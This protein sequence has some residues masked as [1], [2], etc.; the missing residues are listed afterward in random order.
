MSAAKRVRKKDVAGAIDK[1]KKRLLSIVRKL[2]P[3]EA[4]RPLIDGWS[5][6]DVVAHCVYWQGMLA[7]MMGAP[8]PPPSWIPRTTT[9]RELGTDEL[10]RLTVERYRS[11]ELDKVLDDFSFTADLV[12]RI[13]SEMKEANLTLPA[14]EPWGEGTQV[15]QAI[16]GESHGHWKEHSDELEKALGRR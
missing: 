11:F 4:A 10:N 1:E 3:E 9:E 13:V 8:L 16:A 12:K 2:R 14:G 5:A 6:Q 15:H 7:R